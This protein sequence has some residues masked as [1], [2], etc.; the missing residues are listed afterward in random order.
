M[1]NVVIALI[2]FMSTGCLQMAQAEINES[3]NA[4]IRAL[5]REC[6]ENM[7]EWCR[8]QYERVERIRQNAFRVAQERARIMQEMGRSMQRPTVHCTSNV[9]GDYV[10]TQCR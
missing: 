7:T 10:Y 8:I 9:V 2:A 1:K 6:K 3:A 5:D 4:H